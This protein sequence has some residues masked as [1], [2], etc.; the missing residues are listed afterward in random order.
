MNEINYLPELKDKLDSRVMSVLVG[1]GFS[2][3]VHDSFPS[4]YQ[5]MYD[6]VFELFEQE[7]KDA[8]VA[9]QSSKKSKN[10]YLLLPC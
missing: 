1:A 8:Y 9:Q 7:I 6:M 2:K 5:L 3:N 10:Y 4:W